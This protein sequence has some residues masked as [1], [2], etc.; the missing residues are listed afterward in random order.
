MFSA[1]SSLHKTWRLKCGNFRELG[2]RLMSA[3]REISNSLSSDAN[4]SKERL[5]WPIVN[6]RFSNM[7]VGIV[8]SAFPIYRDLFQ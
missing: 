4:S 1:A 7:P 5:E 6:I 2:Y 8:F 3:M